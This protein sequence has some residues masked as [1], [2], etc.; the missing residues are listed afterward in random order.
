MRYKI[1]ELMI[2]MCY[3]KDVALSLDMKANNSENKPKQTRYWGHDRI[4]KENRNSRSHSTVRECECE[5]VISCITFCRKRILVRR[6][7][8]GRSELSYPVSI[9][10]SIK[11]AILN[12][13]LFYFIIMLFPRSIHSCMYQK[14]PVR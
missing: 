10:H 11:C 8:H 4:T 2:K 9:C 6:S 3:P 13:I 5:C 14:N 12:F 7:N 1:R